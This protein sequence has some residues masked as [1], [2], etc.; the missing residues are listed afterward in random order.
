MES[1]PLIRRGYTLV[2][3][4]AVLGIV[5][6]LTAILIPIAVTTRRQG[7]ATSCLSNVR[8]LGIA[9]ISYTQDYDGSYPPALMVEFTGDHARTAAGSYWYDLLLPYTKNH[10]FICPSRW[11]SEAY[12]HKGYACGYAINV[13]LSQP[14]KT[15]LQLHYTG[16]NEALVRAQSNLVTIFDA[17]AGIIAMNIPDF[18]NPVEG[19][20]STAMEEEI[21]AQ[22]PASSR[23][24][25]GANYALADGH[26]KW[27][28]L[29]EFDTECDRNNPCFK[30]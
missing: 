10:L 24:Q 9:I 18:P 23:H 28:R 4:L 21:N 27:L 7:Q 1:Y 17:R 29:N 15:G 14:N 2:E 25:G 6:L 11:V 13:N 12:E 16:Q 8:Q 5:G 26:A 3:L 22:T 30:P 20:Y 19:I